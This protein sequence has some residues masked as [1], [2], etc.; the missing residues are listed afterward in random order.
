[1]PTVAVNFIPCAATPNNGY[2]LTWRVQGS[3]DPYTDQ[4]TFYDS[5]IVFIDELNPE[6]T[7]YEGFLQADCTESGESGSLVGN[8]IPWATDCEPESGEGILIGARV[9]TSLVDH[10]SSMSGIFFTTTGTIAPGLILYTDEAMTTPL[11][12]YDFVSDP[13]SGIVYN[14]SSGTGMIGSDTGL[15]C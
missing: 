14:M 10:C 3:S 6:G 12:G 8:A 7:C 11:L 2:K 13:L 15:A 4:G 5:P 1:M 9:S